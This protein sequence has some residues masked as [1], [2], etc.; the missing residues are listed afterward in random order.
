MDLTGSPKIS[1][2]NGRA[3]KLPKVRNMGHEDICFRICFNILQM[4]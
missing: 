2:G 3:N 1:D 4:F